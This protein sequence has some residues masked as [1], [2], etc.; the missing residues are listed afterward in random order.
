M[1]AQAAARLKA[2]LL[3][4]VVAA[5]GHTHHLQHGGR[6]RG[7]IVALYPAGIEPGH[8]NASATQSV[9][10]AHIV[11]HELDVAESMSP[12]RCGNILRHR[13]VALPRPRIVRLVDDAA[14]SRFVAAEDY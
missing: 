5:I 3:S 2:C 6:V 8:V 10:E 9:A 1:P 13:F 14:G 4:S 12:E 11:G 7:R